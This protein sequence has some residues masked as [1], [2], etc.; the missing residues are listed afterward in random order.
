MIDHGT[1]AAG[2]TWRHYK[3]GLYEVVTLA[4]DEE[5]GLPV[6]VYRGADGK[7]WCRPLRVWS[8]PVRDAIHPDGVRRFTK[9]EGEVS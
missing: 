1:P 8:R 3:G 2:E 7:V 9:Q 4:T 6:V 5:S